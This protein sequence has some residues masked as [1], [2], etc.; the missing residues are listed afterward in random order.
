MYLD[1]SNGQMICIMYRVAT[2][3]LH[4]LKPKYGSSLRLQELRCTFSC[5]VSANWSFC[6][7]TRVVVLLEF[8]GRA[9]SWNSTGKIG[10]IGRH[11]GIGRIWASDASGG[12]WPKNLMLKQ[13]CVSAQWNSSFRLCQDLRI[14]STD[15]AQGTWNV[16]FL[17]GA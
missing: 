9:L 3:Q 7:R 8:L 13:R 15:S 1:G 11:L 6:H 4:N 12:I 10:R 17:T 5:R 16:T 2:A 14:G